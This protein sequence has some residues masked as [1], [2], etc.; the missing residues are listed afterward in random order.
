MEQKIEMF[1]FNLSI[2]GMGKDNFN[3]LKLSNVDKK[4]TFLMVD[5]LYGSHI[6]KADFTSVLILD[7][8]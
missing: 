5:V 8:F 4:L 7:S 3:L 6:L 1:N 2:E